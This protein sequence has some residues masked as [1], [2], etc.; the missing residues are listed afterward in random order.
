M[1][2]PKKLL[3]ARPFGECTKSFLFEWKD[4]SRVPKTITFPGNVERTVAYMRDGVLMLTTGAGVTYERV[5]DDLHAEKQSIVV[6]YS[7][8]DPTVCN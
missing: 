5:V 4:P 3:E 8:Q 2:W 1:I 7:S 6:Y